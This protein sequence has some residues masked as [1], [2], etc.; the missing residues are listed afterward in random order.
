MFV[1]HVALGGLAPSC[2]LVPAPDALTAVTV[3]P[4]FRVVLKAGDANNALGVATNNRL[5]HCR[6]WL[7]QHCLQKSQLV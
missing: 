6:L 4:Y 1:R 5:G 7:E 2:P 3:E